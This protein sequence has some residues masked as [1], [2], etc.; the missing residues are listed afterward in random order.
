MISLDEL[1]RKTQIDKN[2]S[3]Q[4]D[5]ADELASF[6]GKS[7]QEVVEL[8]KAYNVDQLRKPRDVLFTK[9]DH[10]SVVDSYLDEDF[11]MLSLTRLM[12]HYNRFS[13][14]RSALNFLGF[15]YPKGFEGVKFLDYG[16][17]AADYA[18]SFFAHGA[19]PILCDLEGGPVEFAAHRFKLRNCQPEVVPV[20]KEAAYPDLPPCDIVN[21]TEV[22]EHVSDPSQVIFNIW[23][24]LSSHGWFLF[25]DY[26]VQ[27][28]KIGG[29]HLQAAGDKRAEA[30]K[31]LHL[32]FEP[33]YHD[34]QE[35][36]VYIYRKRA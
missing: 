6:Y 34:A 36:Y 15:Y 33:I 31:L 21:A 23:K 12:L 4:E 19:T 30:Y 14:A 20:T 26:P 13:F 16:A 22:L 27:P 17:G 9:Q 7:R 32:L 1:A 18:L 10:S 35:K 8:Y 11:L 28:K 25:S 5:R 2:V 29:A 24:A 3:L